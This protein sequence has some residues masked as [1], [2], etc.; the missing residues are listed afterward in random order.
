MAKEDNNVTKS[1][2]VIS[3]LRW[4]IVTLLSLI[5]FY[6]PI[7]QLVKNVGQF[8]VDRN[9]GD[10]KLQFTVAAALADATINSGKTNDES[11]SQIHKAVFNTKNTIENATTP[12]VL[13]ILRGSKVLWVDDN[14][15]NNVSE[16]NSF[17]TLGINF[18]ISL[19]TEDAIS[20]IKNGNFSAI[21]SDMRRGEKD[22]AGYE[23]LDALKSFGPNPPL[24]FYTASSTPQFQEEA[25]KRGAF[26]ETNS[27]S[28]LFALVVA[29]I[30]S[31]AKR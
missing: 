12:D 26:G 3:L 10:W 25:R 2:N 28:E 14:P 7:A 17:E 24:V 19:S 27:P 1:S 30:Q 15:E 8:S 6:A 23:L 11:N 22:M 13:N 29:A 31:R 4:P 5:I 21:I 16:R 9:G 20:K 18:E